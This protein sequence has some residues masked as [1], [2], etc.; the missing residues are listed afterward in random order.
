M[1][2]TRLIQ[3]AYPLIRRCRF[4][5]HIAD[6]SALLYIN[7]NY[8]PDCENRPG[9]AHEP[10]QPALN[11][12]MPFPRMRWSPPPWEIGQFRYRTVAFFVGPR[13]F[14]SGR[15]FRPHVQTPSDHEPTPDALEA[16]PDGSGNNR[17][18]GM[19]PEMTS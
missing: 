8:L 11:A 18:P 15:V 4:I 17:R 13:Y 3:N 19:T 10:S 6:L 9:S 14:D 16:P 7:P 12:S 5:V 2:I 1:L